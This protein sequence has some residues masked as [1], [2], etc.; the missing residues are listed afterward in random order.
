MLKSCMMKKLPAGAQKTYT[1]RGAS[2]RQRIVDA[3]VSLMYAKGVEGTS[4]DDVRAAASVSK[5][6]LY[7]YFADKDA[8][9]R[10]V[11]SAQAAHVLAA[12]G[13]ALT[14]LD[15]LAAL[16]RWCD[17]ILE[18]NRGAPMADARSDLWQTNWP[19]NPSKLVRCSSPAS[20]HGRTVWPKVLRKCK[21]TANWLA[22]P[23]PGI[24]RSAYCVPF[25]EVCCLPRP[26][27]VKHR[28]RSLSTWRSPMS[29]ATADRSR[30]LPV[31]EHR[32]RPKDD[33]TNQIGPRRIY[34]L[35]FRIDIADLCFGRFVSASAAE[36]G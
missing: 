21:R 20:I 17:C 7:H 6:Q 24:W 31:P 15:S 35:P 8:L 5:S 26:R 10:E 18:L 4:L 2:T 34:S 11:I 23:L 30:V 19:I 27:A 25:K 3:T 33:D 12:Q 13:T 36:Q 32:V 9:V 14:Q 16:R 1:S 22:Q 28:S 29:P